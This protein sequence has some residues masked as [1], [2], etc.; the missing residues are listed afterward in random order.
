MHHHHWQARRLPHRENQGPEPVVHDAG[1]DCSAGVPM[2]ACR[3][4]G[5]GAGPPRLRRASFAKAS[6][7]AGATGDKSRPEVAPPYNL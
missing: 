5:G 2:P 7:F 4:R 3:S 6:P 1:M